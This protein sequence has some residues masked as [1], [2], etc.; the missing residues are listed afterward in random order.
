MSGAAAR[1]VRGVGWLLIAAGVLVGL[2]LVYELLFTNVATSRAQ[3]ALADEWSQSVGES[4][5]SVGE[6]DRSVGERDRSVETEGSRGAD[7]RTEDSRRPAEPV[8]LGAAVAALQFVRPGSQRPPVHEGP[9]FIVEGVGFAELQRGPGHYPST[10]PPGGDGNFAVAG[11]RTT[12]GAPFF[13]LD[14]LR[15]GDEVHVTDRRGRRHTY[16]IREQRVVG[17]GDS[18]VLGP[19]PLGSGVSTL[20]LTTCEPRFSDAQRLVVFAEM[21]T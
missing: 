5:R 3:D 16:E 17:P 13:N 21:I 11:H 20:T 14:D 10:A 1:A 4:D 2:Y 6:S 8:D 19:D 15:A 7:E 9:L 12:F 18:W